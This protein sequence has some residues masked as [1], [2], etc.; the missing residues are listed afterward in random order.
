MSLNSTVLATLASSL[1]A[2]LSESIM[3]TRR[4]ISR[5]LSAAA[6][7]SEKYLI[8]NSADPATCIVS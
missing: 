7:A 6:A 4:I 1:P 3:G 8:F 2:L 5:I